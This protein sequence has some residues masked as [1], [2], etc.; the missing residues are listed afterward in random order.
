MLNMESTKLKTSNSFLAFTD[1]I[2]WPVVTGMVMVSVMLILGYAKYANNTLDQ[3][4]MARIEQER[5]SDAKVLEE[6]KTQVLFME[7]RGWYVLAFGVLIL[8]IFTWRGLSQRS[9]STRR[10]KNYGKSVSEKLSNQVKA[11]LDFGERL[12]LKYSSLTE[13]DLR[14]AEMLVDGLNSK[15]IAAQLNISPS[16]VNTARY[17]LRK[18]M[19]LA[20]ETDLV[21]A[22]KK[23]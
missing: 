4:V 17:R 15:E 1:K 9:Q 18:R 8:S 5:P 7:E 6:N 22:L 3:D 23:V 10:T 12:R 21:V 14:V 2:N 19:L 13:H 11:S 20:P 16:S